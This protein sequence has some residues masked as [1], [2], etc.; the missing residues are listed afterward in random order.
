V[1]MFGEEEAEFAIK[2]LQ[3]LEAE[4]SSR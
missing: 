2:L 3:R 4:C 1:E